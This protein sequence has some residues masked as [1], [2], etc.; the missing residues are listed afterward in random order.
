MVFELDYKTPSTIKFPDNL[1]V[2][3]NSNKIYTN[4][5]D[6][7]LK[8]IDIFGYDIDAKI[9]L[10]IIKGTVPQIIKNLRKKLNHSVADD[11]KAVRVLTPNKCY[12]YLI[13]SE[14]TKKN[15]KKLRKVFNSDWH[16]YISSNI[17]NN[18]LSL[19][20]VKDFF[21]GVTSIPVKHI[22]SGR[23]ILLS[24]IENKWGGIVIDKNYSGEKEYIIS[25]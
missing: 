23:V 17:I 12:T 8:T 4:M 19:K 6:K 3:S 13:Y 5:S 15:C 14:V 22:S 11:T 7:P 1:T 24:K 2:I 21:E 9:L 18:P 25:K 16:M 20:S 10:N